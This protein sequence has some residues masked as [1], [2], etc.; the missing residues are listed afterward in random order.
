MAIAF[1]CPDCGS[2]LKVARNE[3]AGKKIRC[4]NCDEVVL[5]PS[6]KPAG[7]RDSAVSR[8]PRSRESFWQQYGLIIGLGGGAL[9]LATVV[10][11]VLL[12]RDGNED[13]KGL[14]GIGAKDGVPKNADRGA[15]DAGGKDGTKV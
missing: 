3:A 6:P 2:Q 9:V 13:R 5:V 12:N 11:L 1:K 8:S 7:S 14:R 15:K 10:A 4:P